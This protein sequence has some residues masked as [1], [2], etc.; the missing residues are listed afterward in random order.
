MAKTY[1]IIVKQGWEEP[2]EIKASSLAEAIH[3]IDNNEVDPLSYGG[4]GNE[5]YFLRTG[6]ANQPEYKEFKRKEVQA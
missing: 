4:D 6:S 5:R 2:F 1:E 3:M